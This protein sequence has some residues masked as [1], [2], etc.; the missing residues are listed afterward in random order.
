MPIQQQQRP[1]IDIEGSISGLGDALQQGMEFGQKRR[2]DRA[3]RAAFAGGMPTGPDGLPDYMAAAGQILQSGGDMDTAMTLARLAET[4]TQ[5]A[6]LRGKPQFMTGP[7]GSIYTEPTVAGEAPREVVPGTPPKRERPIVVNDTVYDPE[8][9]E[10]IVT[11]PPEAPKPVPPKQPKPPTEDMLKNRQLLSVVSP[12]LTILD[13]TFAD[14]AKPE[15]QIG[16]GLTPEKYQNYAVSPGYQRARDALRTVI[17]SYLYSVS[18]ATAN[19]GEVETQTDI[20]MPKL[21]E[22]ATTTADKRARIKLMADAIKIRAGE[23][24]GVESAGAPAPQQ[25]ARP[26]PGSPPVPGATWSPDDN[27]WFIILPDGTPDWV[28]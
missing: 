27:R 18:G 17:S 12:Q 4:Q 26:P 25:Q 3:T 14:L 21:G 28:E 24:T 2:S 6:Y 10:P 1:N 22:D 8:T 7:G 15:N 11:A 16:A 9:M 23:T 19:P 20:L 13:T 5:N